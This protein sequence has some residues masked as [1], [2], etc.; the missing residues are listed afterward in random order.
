MSELAPLHFSPVAWRLIRISLTV[1]KF[2]KRKRMAMELI[3]FQTPA[4]SGETVSQAQT[5]PNLA[6]IETTDSNI[7]PCAMRGIRHGR[8]AGLLRRLFTLWE[9]ILFPYRPSGNLA[10]TPGAGTVAS[11]F[12]TKQGASAGIRIC[13]LCAWKSPYTVFAMN[14]PGLAF[15][16]SMGW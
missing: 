15:R 7:E 5:Y 12:P 14:F 8:W 13:N 10:Y 9:L 3:D 4:I 2:R 1:G 6:Y 16:D 11:E